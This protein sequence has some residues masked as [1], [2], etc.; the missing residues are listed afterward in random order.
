MSKWNVEF[1]TIH[2]QNVFL[3]SLLQSLIP[4]FNSRLVHHFAALPGCLTS[5]HHF[6]NSLS[7]ATPGPRHLPFDTNLKKKQFM[8]QSYCRAKDDCSVSTSLGIIFFEVWH[9]SEI[10]NIKKNARERNFN[11]TNNQQLS[12]LVSKPSTSKKIP[13]N[14]FNLTNNQQSIQM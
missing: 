2:S 8:R 9:L 6:T 4:F 13:A 14:K 1:I 5:S 10:Q 12:I 3:N 11:L 7:S